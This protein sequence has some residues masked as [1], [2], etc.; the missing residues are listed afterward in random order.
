MIE[1]KE[2]KIQFKNPVT[3]QPT[4]AVEAHYYGRSIRAGVL[5]KEQFF[6]FSPSEIPFTATEEDMINC[7]KE[8]INDESQ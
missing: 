7:I 3:G 5:G 6:R 8:R 4:R 1:I 2:V